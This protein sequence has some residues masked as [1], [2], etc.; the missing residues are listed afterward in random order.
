MPFADAVTEAGGEGEPSS[1]SVVA[2]RFRH[3][4]RVLERISPLVAG[5]GCSGITKLRSRK[6]S[7]LIVYSEQEWHII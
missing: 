3:S 5:G 1:S 4:S 7:G 2:K 6:G